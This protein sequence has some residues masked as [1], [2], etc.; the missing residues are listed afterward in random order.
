MM[1]VKEKLARKTLFWPL[2]I[3]ILNREIFPQGFRKSRNPFAVVL[4]LDRMESGRAKSSAMMQTRFPI[5]LF[6]FFFF[7]SFYSPSRPPPLY[8]LLSDNT[9]VLSTEITH[10]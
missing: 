8:L 1:E 3:G 6:Y 2:A 5:F 7:C 10:T 9:S 4:K